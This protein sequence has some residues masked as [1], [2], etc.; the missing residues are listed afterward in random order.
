[1]KLKRTLNS[2][3][4]NHSEEEM[5]MKILAKTSISPAMSHWPIRDLKPRTGAMIPR[6]S[7]GAAAKSPAA[8]S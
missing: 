3:Q 1:M 6:S 2:S 5:K 8:A 4:K 7:H